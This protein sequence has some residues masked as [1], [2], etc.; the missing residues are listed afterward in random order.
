MLG[1]MVLERVNSINDL[2]VIIDQSMC[3]TEHIDV[4]VGKALVLLRFKRRVSGE[5]KD[6]YTLKALDMS[7]MRQKL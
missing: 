7:L 2:R 3:S 4:M 6:P 1:Q 5:F